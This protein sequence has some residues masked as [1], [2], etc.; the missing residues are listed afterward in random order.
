M[1]VFHSQIVVFYILRY[2]SHYLELGILTGDQTQLTNKVQRI[3]CCPGSVLYLPAVEAASLC[4]HL[5][6]RGDS[7]PVGW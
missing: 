4:C 7:G 2:N 3:L 6:Y 1:R 5:S